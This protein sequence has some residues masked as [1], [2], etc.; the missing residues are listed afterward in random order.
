MYASHL[1]QCERLGQLA[2]RDAVLL[3]RGRSRRRGPP[4]ARRRR[5]PRRRAR[6]F[7]GRRRLVERDEVERRADPRDRRDR[8]AASAGRGRASREYASRARSRRSPPVLGDRDELAAA[9]SRAPRR[10]GFARCRSRSTARISRFGRRLT[11]TTKRKPN[12]PRRPAFRSRE[13]GE[14]RRVGVRAL[15]GGR[16]ADRP[17]RWPIAGC[18]SRPRASPRRRARATSVVARARAGRSSSASRSTK[19]VRPSKSSA[20]SS[21]LSCRGSSRTRTG[22]TRSGTW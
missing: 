2:R 14:H 5:P 6:S 21:T 22:E 12:A 1:N 15:L 18:A 13:L 9:R 20:S 19:R 8:R 7:G 11:K 16:A 4:R 3:R 10:V 17:V